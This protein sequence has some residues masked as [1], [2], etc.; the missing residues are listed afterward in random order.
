[1]KDDLGLRFRPIAINEDIVESCSLFE[2]SLRDTTD[3]GRFASEH[4]QIHQRD[5]K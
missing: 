4:G 5:K 1:M 3:K 2:D